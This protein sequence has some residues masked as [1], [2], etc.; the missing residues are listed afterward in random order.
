M[1]RA[2]DRT[3]ILVRMV[4]FRMKSWSSMPKNR[5]SRMETRKMMIRMP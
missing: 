5:S 2:T 4:G 3:R 1:P